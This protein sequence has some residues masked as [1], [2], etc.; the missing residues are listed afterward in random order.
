MR[1]LPLAVVALTLSFTASAAERDR[2]A[3]ADSY[4]NRPI[5]IVV[6]FPPGASPNDI[7]ARLLGPKLSERLHQQVVVDNRP[8]AAG[9]IGTD[10]VA[11]STPDGHTLLINSTTLTIVPNAY[12]NL[13]FDPVKDLAPI[14]MV[15]AAPQLVMVH[16][17]VPANSVK[18][19]IAHVK[20]RPGQFK[21]SSG[22]NG[23]VPHLAGELLN[24]MAGLQMVHVP[25]KGGAPAAAALLGGEVSMY[26]D[27]PTGSLGMIKAGKVKVLGVASKNRTPLLPDVPTVAEAG[28][29]GY[30]LRIWYGFF[31]PA[32]TPR[33]I[34]QRLYEEFRTALAA[35]EV[36]SR[37]A[38]MGTETVGMPPDEFTRVFHGELQRW[39]KFVRD[40]GLK[41]E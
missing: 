11:K 35:P 25:Y 24:H 38:A 40:T 18:E 41:L 37:F 9:T 16:P 15:A 22:G 30:D 39:A 13:A 4:P 19:L 32:K 2:A 5:R 21:F 27:T 28:L 6:P 12:K 23:T 26:I 7:T 20:A 17:S 1:L 33:V 14:S 10:I 3:K 31:A 34:I 8:G 36:Q 29:P